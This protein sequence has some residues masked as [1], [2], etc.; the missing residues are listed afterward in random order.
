MEENHHNIRLLTSTINKRS[1]MKGSSLHFLLL[2]LMRIFTLGDPHKIQERSETTD[3]D[4]TYAEVN[5]ACMWCSQL[6]LTENPYILTYH[7]RNK[8]FAL[9]KT[10]S[11]NAHQLPA[12]TTQCIS[13]I[14]SCHETSTDLRIR[15]STIQYDTI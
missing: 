1:S 7:A 13:F 15:T 5:I 9:D 10:Q 6:S 2:P 4:A 11:R 12:S 8:V 3:L 14:V